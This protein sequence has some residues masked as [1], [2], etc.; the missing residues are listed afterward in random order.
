M[1]MKKEITSVL[2]CIHTKIQVNNIFFDILCETQ[3]L[4]IY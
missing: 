2:I 1:Y 3:F 4:R